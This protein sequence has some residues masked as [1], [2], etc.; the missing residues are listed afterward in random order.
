MNFLPGDKVSFINEKQ[1]GIIVKNLP[2]NKV[3]VAIEDGFEIEVFEKELVKTGGAQKTAKQP[4]QKIIFP[5]TSEISSN[6]IDTAAKGTISL[7]VVPE[8]IGAVL[9][10]AIE[11]HL[12][13]NTPYH[14]LFTFYSKEKSS[15]IGKEKGSIPSGES[16]FIF[17]SKREDLIDTSSFLIQGLLYADDELPG[18]GSFRKETGI[19]LPDLQTLNKDFKGTT[20]YAKVTTLFSETAPIEEVDI[21]DLM[22]HYQKTSSKKQVAAEKKQPAVRPGTFINEKEVDLHIEELVND[23]AGLSNGEMVK[24]QLERFSKEMDNAMRNH[25]SRI[26]FIHGVGNGRLKQEIRKELR[27]Y[28][29]IAFRDA[30]HTKYGYGA[31]EVLFV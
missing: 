16:Q 21:K 6:L 28:P 9:T 10:G 24:I 3:M 27:A 15:W 7:T 30:D 23:F 17:K 4:E 18:T 13:N 11:H 8:S 25:F 29:G 5:V 22:E 14:L 19:L 20:A 12:V 1:D 26:V 31:T 2:G